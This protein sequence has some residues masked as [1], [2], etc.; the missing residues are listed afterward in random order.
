MSPSIK[1]K[2]AI[3]Q[4]FY[5]VIKTEISK[6]IKSPMLIITTIAAVFLPLMLG[7]LMFIKKYPDLAHSALLLSKASMIPGNADWQNFFSF[8]A[9]IT[10]G[11]GLIL[12]GFVASWIFGREY[13]D[14]TVKD[15]LALPLPRWLIPV[16]KFAVTGL[17]SIYLFTIS[18][19]VMLFTGKGLALSGWTVNYVIHGL[20]VLVE[21]T[22]MLV[23]LNMVTSFIAS[24]SRGYLASI[25]F[26]I[27]ALLLANFIG[28]LGLG[29]YYPWGVPMLYATKAV[30]GAGLE[31]VSF[32]IVAIT[33]ITGFI[34]TILWWRFTDQH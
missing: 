24:W 32:I 29:P 18:M 16:G 10:S 7:L 17:W 28:M 3:C 13:S 15:L 33:S 14:R 2:T 23:G 20:L 12:Y 11:A 31:I 30:E 4:L 27:V 22:V 9:Q 26:M 19:L 1:N 6:A 21:A 8:F 25:G 34:G 5:A